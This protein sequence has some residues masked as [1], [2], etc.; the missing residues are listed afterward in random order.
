MMMHF[1]GWGIGHL[2]PHDFPHKAKVPL[3]SRDNRELVQYEEITPADGL[4][5]KGDEGVDNG[6]LDKDSDNNC[7]VD[8][9][10]DADSPLY[11]YQY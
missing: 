4:E 11:V 1:L 5:A 6:D 7:D 10:A 2:N 8:V 3:A 9:D